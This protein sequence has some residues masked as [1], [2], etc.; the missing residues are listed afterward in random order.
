MTRKIDISTSTLFRFVIIVLGLIFLYLVS[1][2]LILL[3]FSVIIAAGVNGPISWIQKRG[4]NR[5]LA[6]A[7]VYVAILSVFVG[8][9]Y[10][11]IPPL[12]VQIKTLALGLPE[13]LNKFGFSQGSLQ[14]YHSVYFSNFVDGLNSKLSGAASNIFQTTFTFF[15]GLF[16][17]IMVL[18]I[19]LY[20]AA[21]EKGTRKFLFSV[22]P[23]AHR[24]YVDSLV[25]R[26]ETK[27]GAWLRG[28]LLLMFSIAAFTFIGLVLLK[29]KY[30]LI[31]ALLAGLLEVVPFIGPII[32]AVPAIALAFLQ[33]PLLALFV[34]ILYYAIHQLENYI[35]VP[36]IMKKAL[37]LNP[38]V[39]IVALLIGAKLDGVLGMLVAV[40]VAAT[41]GVFFGDLFRDKE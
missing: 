24:E 10:L 38:I 31:L 17:A 2:V 34:T 22:T 35:L 7:F 28:E 16:S 33:A 15:G 19:S 25:S 13:I 1:D 40:P 5:V 18:V 39:V 14:Q 29:V 8:V 36:Q 12:A 23:A 26:I 6:V 9:V 20:L 41:L 32:S 21:Q 3:F 27:L 37:G 4:V 30:A 11:I